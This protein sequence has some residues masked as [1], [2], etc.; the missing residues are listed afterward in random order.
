MAVPSTTGQ[1]KQNIADLQIGDYIALQYWLPNSSNVGK[2][3]NV[4]S[5]GTPLEG[6]PQR[7]VPSGTEIPV[8]GASSAADT[9]SLYNPYT[10][11][12]KVGKGLLVSDRV[13]QTSI[14]W[15][16]LNTSKLIQG[17]TATIGGVTGRI[18]SLTGG[19]AYADA[20]GNK[21]LTGGSQLYGCWPTNNEWDKYIVNFPQELIQPGKTLDDVFHWNTGTI[22][23]CQDTPIPIS[24]PPGGW[25]NNSSG[26]TQRGGNGDIKRLFSTVSSYTGPSLIG[27]RPVF[28][29]VE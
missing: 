27:F 28:E 3:S 23:W 14:S 7:T 13:C 19:V 24:S 8:T 16:T 18:R 20:N 6:A 2:L 4:G 15:D 1:L 12:V 10:Y 5:T 21:S 17:V 26:R 9:N 11:L 22:T 29:Y 25:A